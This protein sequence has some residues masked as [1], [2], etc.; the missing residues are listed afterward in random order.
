MPTKLDFF[1][2]KGFCKKK[3]KK[4]QLLKHEKNEKIIRIIA[5]DVFQNLQSFL[6]RY[7]N[8]KIINK[9]C[10]REMTR[11]VHTLILYNKS[12]AKKRDRL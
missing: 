11:Y 3:K 5:V 12:G 9:M 8:T 2:P 7:P 1:F 10:V 6:N 4:N